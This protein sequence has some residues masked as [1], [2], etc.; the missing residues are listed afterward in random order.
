[1][2]ERSVK[3]QSAMRLRCYCEILYLDTEV[4]VYRWRSQ[5]KIRGNQLFTDT[6]VMGHYINP[7]GHLDEIAEF[8]TVESMTASLYSVATT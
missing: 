1:V 2:G 5:N 6:T 3:F 8:Y 7:G 4:V